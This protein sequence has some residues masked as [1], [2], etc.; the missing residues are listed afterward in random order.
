MLTQGERLKEA[1]EILRLN[2]EEFADKIG[3]SR[4]SVSKLESNKGN[5]G[6]EI[7]CNL[8][9]NLNIS[10]DWLLSG[11]GEM[12]IQEN[13]TNLSEEFR[14]IVKAEVVALLHEYGV[15]DTVK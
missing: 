11:K 1:R 10:V 8:I 15:I 6:I 12:F 14:G 2:Q 4:A 13:K 9:N 7:Y 5:F 3:A